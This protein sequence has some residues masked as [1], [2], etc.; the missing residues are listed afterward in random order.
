MNNRINQNVLLLLTIL[1]PNDWMSFSDLEHYLQI[2]TDKLAAILLY[3]VKHGI[4][5][6]DLDA[7]TIQPHLS[8]QA[9]QNFLFSNPKIKS[10]NIHELYSYDLAKHLDLQ[11]LVSIVAREELS[12]IKPKKVLENPPEKT[13]YFETLNQQAGKQKS[14]SNSLVDLSKKARRSKTSRY[15][16]QVSKQKSNNQLLKK[17]PSPR[18]KR[19]AKL[20]SSKEKR[21]KEGIQ[22][23][24]N[25]QKSLSKLRKLRKS[26][27]N[28]FD[29]GA[30]K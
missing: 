24:K 28:L 11:I 14:R 8:K 23:L 1:S 5:I 2:P 30:M 22:D 17:P 6:A 7:W 16:V 10:Y 19:I 21:Y 18:R 15:Q 3:G 4:L 13:Y 25:L 9:L 20:T 29:R 26:D 12:S 27:R